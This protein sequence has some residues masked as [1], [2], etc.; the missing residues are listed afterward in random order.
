M[1]DK[2]EKGNKDVKKVREKRQENWALGPKMSDI[3]LTKES[4]KSNL[5]ENLK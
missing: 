3:F 2:E 4:L 1:D 5:L